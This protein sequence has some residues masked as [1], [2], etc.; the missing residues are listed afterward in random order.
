MSFKLLS[1]FSFI[2]LIAVACESEPTTRGAD[3]GEE[4]VAKELAETEDPQGGNMCFEQN[5]QGVKTTLNQI[6][7]AHV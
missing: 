2:I 6:G 4:I 3:N 7:R 1:F 5:E